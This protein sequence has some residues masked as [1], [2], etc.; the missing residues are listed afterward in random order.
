MPLPQDARWRQN[1]IVRI[2]RWKPADYRQVWLVFGPFVASGPLLGG[3]LA[4]LS[5]GGLGVG[6]FLVS[7]PMAV[8]MF[9]GS[10]AIESYRLGRRRDAATYA[11]W[12]EAHGRSGVE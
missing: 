9:A 3:L 7:L 1:V 12:L 11:E 8:V 6:R 5:H 2:V 4:G 10:G